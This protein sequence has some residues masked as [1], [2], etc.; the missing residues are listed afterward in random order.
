MLLDVAPRGIITARNI[1]RTLCS[2]S[3]FVFKIRNDFFI[4]EYRPFHGHGKKLSRMTPVYQW[5]RSRYD[6]AHT[7]Q[8]F[9]LHSEN[10]VIEAL[11]N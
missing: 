9:R 1:D 6:H 2:P 5:N 3:R 11:K 7:M 8:V 10:Q 4:D